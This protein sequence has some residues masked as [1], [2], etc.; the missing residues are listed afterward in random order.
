MKKPAL[1][2]GLFAGR[3]LTRDFDFKGD[4]LVLTAHERITGQKL[5]LRWIKL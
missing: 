3:S 2:I 4:T 5:R 1:L